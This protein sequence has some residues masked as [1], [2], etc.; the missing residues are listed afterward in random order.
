MTYFAVPEPVQKAYTEHIRV[1]NNF[2]ERC[3]NINKTWFDAKKP[4]RNKHNA[5]DFLTSFHHTI[6]S[7]Q[8]HGFLPNS[9]QIPVTNN[10]FLLNGA[11]RMAA[12]IVL[13]KNV[14]FQHENYS[15]NYRWNY[16]YFKH[17]GLSTDLSNLVMLEWMRIQTN[18]ENLSRKVS[19]VSI[20]ANDTSKYKKLRDIVCKKCST[21]NGILYE[22]SIEVTMLGMGQLVTHMY[23]NQSWISK[24]IEHMLSQ[25]KSDFV[26]VRFIFFFA[27]TELTKC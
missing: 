2:Q 8:K 11:H 14:T 12:A 20:F 24:K 1:W 22:H 25:F 4:C 26:T 6:H 21:D 23:G 7:I 16:K 13:E 10:G 18:L 3:G 5:T 9:S 27:K 19:V 17:M 15:R